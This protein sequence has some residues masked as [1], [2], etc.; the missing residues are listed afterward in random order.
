M[1]QAIYRFDEVLDD[2]FNVMLLGD[3]YTLLEFQMKNNLTENLQTPF[4]TSRMGDEA[5]NSGAMMYL[6]YPP[7]SFS[8]GCTVYFNFSEN[9]VLGE[10]SFNEIFNDI[11]NNKIHV[12]NG[13]ICLYTWRH[14]A[15]FN[16]QAIDMLYKCSQQKG[17]VE[18]REHDGRKFIVQNPVRQR[19]SCENGYYNVQVVTETPD[20]DL[21]K[22]EFIFSNIVV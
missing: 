18:E 4:T 19:V 8:I 15:S 11:P 12:T 9:R 1:E 22:V 17:Y 13:C 5:I 6:G 14:L 16:Q 20:G 2:G 7:Y 10:P 3:P 21:P